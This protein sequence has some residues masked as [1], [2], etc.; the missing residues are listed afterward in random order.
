[1][2]S[3][4]SP[5]ELTT[6]LPPDH[7][8]QPII[9]DL[10]KKLLVTTASMVRPYDPEADGWLVLVEEIDID[11]PLTEIWADDAY[12]LIDIPF[13]GTTLQKG[14]YVSVFLASNQFGLVF[15]IPDEEWLPDELRNVLEDN[16]VPSPDTSTNQP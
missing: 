8:A 15:V 14:M 4:K 2:I 13:E 7:P 10:A 16:L 6:K 11:R 1:M 5:D 3:F 9:E 12:R